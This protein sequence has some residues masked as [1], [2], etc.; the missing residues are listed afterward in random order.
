METFISY[1]SLVALILVLILL[2]WAIILMYEQRSRKMTSRSR[3]ADL[4][5]KVEA[6]PEESDDD[7]D[8]KDQYRRELY[9]EYF[10]NILGEIEKVQ[11]TLSKMQ[12]SQAKK[13]AESKKRKSK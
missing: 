13:A 9:L 1:F 5:K 8:K 12:A 4:R 2:T 10:D 7:K 3:L 6:L 11:G